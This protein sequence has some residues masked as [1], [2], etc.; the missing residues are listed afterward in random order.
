[1]T[2]NEELMEIARLS[3][4]GGCTKCTDDFYCA[5]CEFEASE[6]N[7]NDWYDWTYPWYDDELEAN[8]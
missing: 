4:V 5:D 7:E 6:D 8:E 3:D 1:M 2:K